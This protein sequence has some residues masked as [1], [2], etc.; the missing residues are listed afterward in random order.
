[1]TRS[2]RSLTQ[3][4]VN[5]AKHY[6]TTPTSWR[7]RGAGNTRITRIPFGSLSTVV[8]H[9]FSSKILV[10][11]G[12]AFRD[13]QIRHITLQVGDVLDGKGR[14]T[15]TTRERLNGLLDML[16]ELGAVPQ[17]TRVF[18]EKETCWI[19]NRASRTPF[20]AEHPIV[21]V[22]AHPEQ[23]TFGCRE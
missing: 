21:T 10:V 19:G 5:Q 17:D 8:V 20:D 14:P 15:R 9:L 7:S 23:L 22:A 16:G 12:S 18:I 3:F 2:N 6:L 13:E 11:T 1:M 4:A